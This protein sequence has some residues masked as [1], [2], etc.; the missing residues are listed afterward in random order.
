MQTRKIFKTNTCSEI[1]LFYSL[2]STATHHWLPDMFHKL[3]SH[4]SI[5]IT[6]ILEIKYNRYRI[7]TRQAEIKPTNE[8]ER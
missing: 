4:I 6:E 7:S 1:L 5:S 3:Y 8:S 2:N